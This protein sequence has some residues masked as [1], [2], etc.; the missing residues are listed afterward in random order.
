[1]VFGGGRGGGGD[2]SV[3]SEWGKRV[4]PNVWRGIWR[5]KK[6]PWVFPPPHVHP[7]GEKRGGLKTLGNDK[8]AWGKLGCGGGQTGGS[9][10]E[11]GNT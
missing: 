8:K 6:K 10:T 1:M 3:C 9:P 7:R 5:K 4:G 11:T 2:T